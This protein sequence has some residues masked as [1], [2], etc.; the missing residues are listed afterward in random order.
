MKTR[1][2][3]GLRGLLILG[4]AFAL[5]AV[6]C[7][8][9]DAPPETVV[10]TEIVEVEVEVPGE[11][12]TEIVEVEV[13]GET[14]TV[15]SIVTEVVTEV[16][17]ETVEVEVTA[18]PPPPVPLSESKVRWAGFGGM[19]ELLFFVA[20][21]AG[22]F[23][24][25]GLELE[26]IELGGGVDLFSA[27]ASGSVAFTQL[28]TQHGIRAVTRGLDF[29]GIFG[30]SHGPNEFG[31]ISPEAAA[32]A[33]ITEDST[34]DEKFEA[35]RGLKIGTGRPGS[36]TTTLAIGAMEQRGIDTTSEV[37]LVPLGRGSA[38]LPA[39]QAREIDAFFWI[40]PETQIAALEPGAVTIDFRVL[41]ELEAVNWASYFTTDSYILEHPDT[42]QAFLR[43]VLKARE[44]A[45]ANE[46]D[47]REIARGRFPDLEQAAFD[48]SFQ[49]DYDSLKP[50][51]LFTEDGFEKG[52]YILNLG[53]PADAPN[54][55][56]MTAVV[57]NELVIQAATELGMAIG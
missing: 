41:S 16:V 25:E 49:I 53:L 7:G 2:I 20:E 21:D 34:I 14:V 46:A 5:V 33:G 54:T 26:R 56:L 48:S 13:P 44:W 19:S 52:R 43:A 42:V 27:L 39:F 23:E 47:A 30:F 24:A 50:S 11:T 40:P 57:T 28:G 55:T 35:L 10:V 17:T 15:T 22:F 9:D 51:I 1:R 12:V 45:L 36:T 4:V 38:L 32:A 18:P 37:E 6:A 3:G 29:R 31:I 8:G